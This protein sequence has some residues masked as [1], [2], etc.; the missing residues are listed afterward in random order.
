VR[1]VSEETLC[2][3]EG[4]ERERATSARAVSRSLVGLTG[5]DDKES[6]EEKG[7]IFPR[8]LHFFLEGVEGESVLGK[9]ELDVV[10]SSFERP[11]REEWRLYDV[12]WVPLTREQ[13]RRS[14]GRG[15]RFVI[16]YR[17]G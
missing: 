4:R 5:P 10:V 17:Y 7:I 12:G 6:V 3:M 13:C 15:R 16:G 14:R 2:G 9:V 8:R 11:A 1:V